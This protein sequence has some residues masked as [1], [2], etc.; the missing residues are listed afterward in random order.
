MGN[1]WFAGTYGAGVLKMT[2][3]G[4]W[5]IFADMPAD[6]VVNPNALLVTS[7]HVFAG[8][9]GR[10]LW[11]FDRERQRWTEVIAGLPSLNVTALAERDGSLFVGTDNGL[12]RMNEN[13]MKF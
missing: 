3:G 2:S 13:A 9:L 4:D 1:E 6:V 5:E 8:T 11:T 7:S 12:A 10:G